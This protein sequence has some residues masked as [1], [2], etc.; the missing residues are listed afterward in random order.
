MMPRSSLTAG[1][2][3]E[4]F[5]E[6]QNLEV[7]FVV[8]RTSVRDS[9]DGWREKEWVKFREVDDEKAVTLVHW[10]MWLPDRLCKSVMQERREWIEGMMARGPQRVAPRVVFVEEI[11]TWDD[12]VIPR[13]DGLG[14]LFIA[15]FTLKFLPTMTFVVNIINLRGKIKYEDFRVEIDSIEALS[16]P[17]PN[18]A[19][20]SF[21]IQSTKSTLSLWNRS[22]T[23]KGSVQRFALVVKRYQAT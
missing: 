20:P 23:T 1:V 15:K 11:R 2:Y 5:R 4:S 6:Y 14:W 7:V 17:D 10:A 13:P 9:K 19:A 3:F 21:L 22:G 8:I 12:K 16:L 18:S